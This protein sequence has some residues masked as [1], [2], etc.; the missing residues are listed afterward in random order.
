M[1]VIELYRSWYILGVLITLSANWASISAAKSYYGDKSV[2]AT[3]DRALEILGRSGFRDMVFVF[4]YLFVFLGIGV[5]LYSH[6]RIWSLLTWRDIIWTAGAVG[7]VGQ[8]QFS[9]A[10]HL[11]KYEFLYDGSPTHTSLNIQ[12]FGLLLMIAGLLFGFLAKDA[13]PMVTTI[14]DF[15]P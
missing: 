3:L 7:F 12:F 15:V 13:P 4:S 5:M 2:I 14:F 11:M 9:L 1:T 8:R 6:W 10:N